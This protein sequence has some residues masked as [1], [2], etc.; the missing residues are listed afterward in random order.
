LSQ[1]GYHDGLKVT[2]KFVLAAVMTGD[3]GVVIFVRVCGEIA[4]LSLQSLTKY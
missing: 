4:W 2:F 3:V 1:L